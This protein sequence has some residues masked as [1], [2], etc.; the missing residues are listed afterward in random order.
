MLKLGSGSI[1]MEYNLPV[2]LGFDFDRFANLPFGLAIVADGALPN[3]R[4]LMN[5]L[6]EGSVIQL[7]RSKR[8]YRLFVAWVVLQVPLKPLDS[9]LKLMVY[10]LSIESSLDKF[11]ASLEFSIRIQLNL[12]CFCG[13]VVIFRTPFVD[14]FSGGDTSCC[15][16][17]LNRGMTKSESTRQRIDSAAKS[18]D[19]LSGIRKLNDLSFQLSASRWRG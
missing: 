16:C 3:V 6:L 19:E 4:R 11:L 2:V 15:V 12:L 13:V 9:Q 8:S 1:W 7:L 17:F 18:S 5:L 10:C 14:A